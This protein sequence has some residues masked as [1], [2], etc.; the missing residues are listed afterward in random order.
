MS[1]GLYNIIADDVLIEDNVTIGN[2]N[3]IASG[4][5]IRKGTIVGNYCDIGKNND[6]GVNSIIQGRVRTASNCVIE[7]NVTIKY[8][9]ILT[10]SVLL[11]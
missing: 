9:T 10:E 6:I 1:I 2:F 5:K 11:K 3:I 8:G 7:Q 4:T